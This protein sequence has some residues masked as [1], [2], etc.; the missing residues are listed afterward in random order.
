MT[1]YVIE[2]R[3]LTEYENPVKQG[4]YEFLIMPCENETQKVKHFRLLHSMRR[5]PFTARNKY[6]FL[7]HHFHLHSEPFEYFSLNL[8]AQVA[9]NP[10]P[11]DV[12]SNLSPAEEN[13]VLGGIEFQMDQ[14][15]FLQ[16]TPLCLLGPGDFPAE[17]L[18]LEGENVGSYLL[19]LNAGIHRLL[20]YVPGITDAGTQAKTA[21]EIGKGV[22]QDYAH[23]M[24]GILRPQGIPAR[25]VSGYLN[26]SDDRSDSQLHAWVEALIPQVG[27]RGF[28][29]ANHLQEND[30]F[31][32]I[33][34]G[35][36]YLDCQPI[37]GVLTT[38]GAHKTSYEVLVRNS[39]DYNWFLQEQQQQ[40][41]QQ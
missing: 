9:K 13:A 6:G 39:M 23:V 41:Q 3:T 22:C 27:W 24:I 14:Q 7:T 31:I 30:H 28:D 4:A 8:L 35:R 12:F 37:K 11:L 1:D 36:D 29:P 16:V 21:L 5:E 10:P 2:Y 32:K 26:L 18:R 34:H 25:Y 33:A 19:R 17:L 15:S 20:Q 38:E 40:Q